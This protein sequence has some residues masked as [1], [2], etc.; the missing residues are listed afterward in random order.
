MNAGKAIYYLLTNNENVSAVVSSR[1]YP[2]VVAQDAQVPF[3]FFEMRGV[4]PDSFKPGPAEID[5]IRIEVS[6]ISETYDEVVDLG[7]KIRGALDRVYGTYNGVN[8]ESIEFNDAT[9]DVVSKPRRY[10]ITLDFTIRILRGDFTLATGSPITGYQLGQLSDVSLDD[11]LDRQALVYDEASGD[12]INDGVGSLVIPVRNAAPTAIAI[13][14]ILKAVGAQGDRVL[15][16]AYSAGDDPKLLV[17]VASEA[18]AGSADGH[19]QT[20][21]ELRKVDTENYPVGT[22][23]YPGAGGVWSTSADQY[24]IALAIVTRQQVNTGR[25]FVRS[26]TPGTS[27]SSGGAETLGALNDVTITSPSDGQALVYDEINRVWINEPL[28]IPSPPPDTTDQ[29]TEGTTNLYFTTARAQ[30]VIDADSSLVKSVN[31]ELPDQEGDVSLDTTSVPEGT[32]LYHTT[33]R[34]NAVIGAS[35]VTALSDVTSAGSGAIITTAERSKLSG[36]EAGAEVNVNAD[37]NAAT[38]DAAILNKPTIPTELGDLGGNADEI[39]DG[40]T[41][42]FFTSAERTKLS[43]IATGAEVNV[44]AD[45]NAVSG[46]AQILNKPSIPSAIGD[47]SDVPGTLGTAG[48]VL[49]VNSGATALEYVDQSGGTATD[50]DIGQAYKTTSQTLS[51]TPAAIASWTTEVQ[52][53]LNIFNPTTGEL[54]ITQAGKY[55]LVFEADFD[56]SVFVD[57]ENPFAYIDKNGTE[58]AGS[59]RHSYQRSVS[60]GEASV[61][62]SMVYEHTSGTAV[63]KAMVGAEIGSST[64]SVIQ[65]SMSY[66]TLGGAQGVQGVAGNS[67]P[68]DHLVWNGTGTNNAGVDQVD[69]GD[70]PGFISWSTLSAYMA[71]TYDSGSNEGT[72]ERY[73]VPTTGLYE[74]NGFCAIYN[75]GTLASDVKII[76][77]LE[78]NGTANV[79]PLLARTTKDVAAANYDGVGGTAVMQLTAG[80]TIAPSIYIY[81]SGTGG[82]LKVVYYSTYIHFAI[83]RIA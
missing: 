58:I 59:R 34:V 36:I 44:K 77:T 22:I 70:T 9:I 63:F 78:K 65:A 19:A 48:Q 18:I 7:E 45:W 29:L 14:T 69:F 17:G 35:S 13:G 76:V 73:V 20:Y 10:V 83:R 81:R 16:G 49:A 40:Q 1:V 75:N 46:D 24:N 23:L 82:D 4:T 68:S 61:S 57:R 15:V 47:L 71:V 26:W 27:T 62:L 3:I 28:S 72:G 74:V 37:W 11:P 67:L 31:S 6:G 52:D 80:D 39:A 66:T 60:S 8:V 38:G 54:T 64:T 25:I 32:N 12:W 53:D 50:S 21:G 41:N 42:L 30:A 56:M 51:T 33:A 55:M 5:E 2:E 43:G 79:T